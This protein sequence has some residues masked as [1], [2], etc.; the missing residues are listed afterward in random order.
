MQDQNLHKTSYS[1]FCS[2]PFSSLVVDPNKQVRPC[3]AYTGQSWGNIQTSSIE[4]IL[5]HPDRQQLKLDVQN[6]VWNP[7]CNACKNAE[8]KTG[9]S[10]RTNTYKIIPATNSIKYLEYNGSNTCNLICAMCGPFFSSAWVG[11]NQKYKVIHHHPELFSDVKVHSANLNFLENFLKVLDFH[12]LEVLVLKGGEPF[13]NKENLLMLE[14]LDQL[15]ILNK[16]EVRLVTNGTVV[17]EQMLQLLG[18]SKAVRVV[19]SKDG[20]N[21][22]NKWIRW[23]DTNPDLSSDSHVKSIIERLL[24]LPN[25]VELTNNFALQ[26][27]N[28]FRLEEHL[29]WWQSEIVSLDNRVKSLK[30]FDYF[31]YSDNLNVRVLT[32]QTRNQLIEKYSLIN[33]D[34]TYTKIIEYMKLP[35]MG[36][37]A[38][39]SF[40][41]FT[42]KIDKTRDVSITKIVPEIANELII[43]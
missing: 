8:E 43:L 18:K 2:A 13:L 36:N 34:G 7:G 11:F 12:S 39:N 24:S 10:V 20:T 41:W 22:L 21:D 14:H 9:K 37:Y 29:N 30:S 17:N 32:D 1:N 28:V 4:E 25:L 3:C 26:V 23:N 31:V 38:H 15:N 19:L 35:Y 16:I 27:Y 5:N 6:K 40:V 33:Q 42:E